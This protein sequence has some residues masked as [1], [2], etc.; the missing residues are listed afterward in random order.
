MSKREIN[1]KNNTLVIVILWLIAT[2]IFILI[3]FSYKVVPIQI[4]P[5]SKEE[6]LYKYVHI[7]FMLYLGYIIV[8][9]AK[10]NSNRIL[11][12]ILYNVGMD[13]LVASVV[14][15][16]Q[17]IVPFFSVAPI[18]AIFPM[19]C[20]VY[21][22]QNGIFQKRDSVFS[23]VYILLNPIIIVVMTVLNGLVLVNLHITIL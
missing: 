17:Q 22:L 13:Y 3:I 11:N 15:L 18:A 7:L 20:G 12:F 1:K 2:I 6:A 4:E 9:T 19:S 21:V 14:I 10:R 23:T 5:Y 16:M 8:L